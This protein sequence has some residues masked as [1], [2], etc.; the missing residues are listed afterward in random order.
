MQVLLA[1]G[2]NEGR[3]GPV[4]PQG[5]TCSSSKLPREI[6]NANSYKFPL[7]RFS[8]QYFSSGLSQNGET[9]NGILGFLEK[10]IEKEFARGMSHPRVSGRN[11]PGNC[12]PCVVF[13]MTT[14]RVSF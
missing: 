14:V 1:W 10:D 13:T 5:I 2:R 6:N 7:L 9:G 4:T 3:A 11:Y 8:A 12:P